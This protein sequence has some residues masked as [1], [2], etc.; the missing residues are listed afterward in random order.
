M[1]QMSMGPVAHSLIHSTNI[2]L[3]GTVLDTGDIAVN[4]T[5][6]ISAFQWGETGG[7]QMNKLIKK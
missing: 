7:K 2:Y 4:E 6:K 3:A 5:E 1:M